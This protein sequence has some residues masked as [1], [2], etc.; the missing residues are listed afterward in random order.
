MARLRHLAN[1]RAAKERKRQER[2]AAGWTPEPR[3]TRADRW[4]EVS[5]RDAR[6]G[7]TTGFQPLRSARE[8]ARWSL[9][10]LKQW[11]PTP[12]SYR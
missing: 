6:T 4:L 2:I 3:H 8:A 7:E 12:I 11:Q 1:M 10:L 5:F 9:R